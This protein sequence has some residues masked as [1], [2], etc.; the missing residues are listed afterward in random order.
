MATL[1]CWEI[2]W[3]K[4]LP[5]NVLCLF[6]LPIN[7]HAE[8][9][10]LI[11]LMVIIWGEKKQPKIRI[12]MTCKI[13]ISKKGENLIIYIFMCKLHFIIFWSSSQ[14]L[15]SLVISTA[16]LTLRSTQTWNYYFDLL[17]TAL[18]DHTVFRKFGPQMPLHTHASFLPNDKYFYKEKKKPCPIID[19]RRFQIYSQA[20]CMSRW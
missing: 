12:L 3:H 7:I 18:L 2:N 20:I 15:Q 10:D 6:G 4:N 16:L 11:D 9:W 5:K 17:E 8:V 19:Q 1:F 13:W 14:N